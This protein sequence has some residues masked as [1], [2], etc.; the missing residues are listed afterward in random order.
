MRTPDIVL[1]EKTILLGWDQGYII[2]GG[3]LGCD[4]ASGSQNASSEGRRRENDPRPC[5]M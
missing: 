5:P 4:E 3:P 2:P 1:G